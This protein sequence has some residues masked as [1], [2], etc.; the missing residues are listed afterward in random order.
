MGIFFIRRV[1]LIFGRLTEQSRKKEL[2]KEFDYY[3]CAMTPVWNTLLI[4]KVFHKLILEL[5]ER[6]KQII[7]RNV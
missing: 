7:I 1:N 6:N 2:N 3:M 5:K 4:F